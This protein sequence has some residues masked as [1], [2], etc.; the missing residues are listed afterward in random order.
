MLPKDE[1]KILVYLRKYYPEKV[2]RSECQKVHPNAGHAINR[3]IDRGLVKDRLMGNIVLSVEGRD[4][5]DKYASWYQYSNLW[6]QEYIKHGWIMPI[7]TFILGI[8]AGFALAFI[9]AR[10][11]PD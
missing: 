2:S 5:A 9:Q 8:A 1:R 6:Y 11:F 4:L 10:F 3:L 7:L